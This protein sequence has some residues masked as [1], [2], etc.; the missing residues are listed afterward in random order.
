MR[1]KYKRSLA[2]YDRVLNEQGGGCA[3]C[4]CA[5]EKTRL[6]W[7]HDHTCCPGRVTCGDCVRE[8]VCGRCNR[9]VGALEAG[10]YAAHSA[11]I[12]KWKKK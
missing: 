2:D 6:A 10:T 3:I 1:Y 5:P 7:D 12:E 9:V 11:Y 8:L 4:G